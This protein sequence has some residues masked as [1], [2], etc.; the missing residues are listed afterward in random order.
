V[1][2]APRVL[3]RVPIGSFLPSQHWPR[4]TASAYKPGSIPGETSQGP[5]HPPCR[6]RPYLAQTLEKGQAKH[7]MTRVLRQ[8]S[9]PLS[10]QTGAPVGAVIETPCSSSTFF[11]AASL[12]KRSIFHEPYWAFASIFL[13]MEKQ[14]QSCA[15]EVVRH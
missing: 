3:L 14:A 1:P 13:P 8:R 7:E 12:Q 10:N 11:C 4:P 2:R 9:Y 5:L 15:T 6:W